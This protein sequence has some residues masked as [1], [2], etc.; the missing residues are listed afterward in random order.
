NDEQEYI[1]L[2]K[3]LAEDA[4]FVLPTGDAATRMP[5]YPA[6]LSVIYRSQE[7]KYWL[8]A[9]DI[10]QA[11]MG[12]ISTIGLA[13]I[14]AR[15]ADARAGIVAGLTA[16]FYAPFIYV[17]S[18][19]LTETL[20]LLLLVLTLWLYVALCLTPPKRF[21]QRLAPWGVSVLLGLSALTR[22]N[23]ALLVIP[24]VVHA[25][26][27][28]PPGVRRG[29]RV[30]AIVLPAALIVGGWMARNQAVVG[31]FTL[32]SIGGLNFYLGH[33]PDYRNDA[34][35]GAADYDRFNHLRRDGLS[36]AEADASLYTEGWA[37]V[38]AHPAEVA[39][40]WF[41]KIRVWFTPTTRSMGPSLLLL[42]AGAIIASLFGASG[43]AGRRRSL[44]AGLA[45]VW[46]GCALA[47]AAWAYFTPVVPLV[48]S[49]FLLPLGIPALLFFRPA[50]RVRG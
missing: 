40:N 30:V 8:S 7:S 43:E 16:A 18:Q 1:D 5:M 23:A 44:R 46:L 35:L 21:E 32:S 49:K 15:L 14:A 26:L 25:W 34:G 11:L 37:F 2:A 20:A 6:L 28:S 12:V 17:E 29:V 41:R 39:G 45:V 36:E 48:S 27:R 50:L 31:K 13:C 10:M 19:L 42:V 38:K 24:F 47:Y 9:V 3:S 33:N 4:R 22:A